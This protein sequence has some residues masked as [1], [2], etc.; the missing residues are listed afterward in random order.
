MNELID[1]KGL[2]CGVPIILAKKALEVH[3]KIT[4]IVDDTPNVEN[5]KTLGRYL[6]CEVNIRNDKNGCFYVELVRCKTLKIVS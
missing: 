2:G 6:G 3:N 5:L 4:V 1:A